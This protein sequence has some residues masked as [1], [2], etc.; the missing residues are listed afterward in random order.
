MVLNITLAGALRGLEAPAN[1]PFSCKRPIMDELP[2]R[3]IRRI[4][5][6]FEEPEEG[7]YSIILVDTQVIHDAWRQMDVSSI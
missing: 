5:P 4:F 2:K 7:V 3:R 6:R 1:V